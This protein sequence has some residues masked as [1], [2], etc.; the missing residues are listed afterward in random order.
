MIS[1]REKKTIEFLASLQQS[2]PGAKPLK[3][4]AEGDSMITFE[5]DA[6]QRS[7]VMRLVGQYGVVFKIKMEATK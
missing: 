1:K 5:A 7:E 3:F 6:S 4:S 2:T